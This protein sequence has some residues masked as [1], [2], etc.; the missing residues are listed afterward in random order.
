MKVDDLDELTTDV[1]TAAYDKAVEQVTQIVR[2]ET[3]EANIYVI[4][5]YKDCIPSDKSKV[6]EQH[7]SVEM[8]ILDAVITKI[9]KSMGM[10]AEKV[11]SA[12]HE[13]ANRRGSLK[14]IQIEMKELILE[15]LKQ[16][17]R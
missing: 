15:R 17:K 5:S 11:L 3:I 7:R 6:P 13:P 1:L 16:K 4:E 12:L 10:V 8:K 9:L 14:A 2:K